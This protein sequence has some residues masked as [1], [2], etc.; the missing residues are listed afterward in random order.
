MEGQGS[1]QLGVA[2]QD[3]ARLVKVDGPFLSLYLPL[4]PEIDNASQRSEATWKAARQDL[5]ARGVTGE[6]LESHE[7]G[8]SRP[9]G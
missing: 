6:V 4:E 2:A 3:L 1:L 5:E 8:L 9:I 7:Y